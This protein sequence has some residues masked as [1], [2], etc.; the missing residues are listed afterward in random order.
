M[1]GSINAANFAI[2]Y[3]PTSSDPNFTPELQK[4]YIGVA[5]MMRAFAYINL[6]TLWGDIPLY[7][8]FTASPSYAYAKSPQ[9]EILQFAIEDLKYAVDNIPESWNDQADAGL[10]KKAAAAGFLA[11]AYLYAKD[12]PNAETAAKNA[13][14]IA[15]VCGYGLMDDYAYMM[16]EASQPNKE[17]IFAFQFI[18]NQSG[19]PL[20]NQGIV[21]RGVR[22]NPGFIQSLTF[23]DGFGYAVPTRNLVDAFEPGDPRRK[24]SMWLAGDF[25]AIYHGED[26]TY[27]NSNVTPAVVTPYH[28]GDTI[29]YQNGWSFGNVN[30]RKEQSSVIGLINYNSGYDLPVLRYAE[31]YL[32]YSEALIENNK[33]TEGM[34]QL[35]KVRAR[36]S[37]NM[38]PLTAAD[39]AD[40]R[41]KLRHERRIELNMEGIRMYD[42]HRWGIME[43]VFGAGPN[44]NKILGKVGDNT[45]YKQTNLVFPRDNLFPIPQE[46]ISA[47]PLMTQNPGY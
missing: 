17:F 42:L 18:P 41:A 12:F 9:S 15:D 20:S 1:Y 40:A 31:L 30:T 11:R 23:G 43:E 5:K 26:I 38:P 2:D 6:T 46:E 19:A 16:S 8:N 37:V 27:T 14:D 44:T 22:D 28:E 3:I 21:Y 34:A 4:K 24:A 25:F 29:K 7:K 13:L 36:P 33:I 39:Q 35:N 47:N 32:Y 45:I 10:P